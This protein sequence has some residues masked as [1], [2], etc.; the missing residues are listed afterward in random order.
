MINKNRKIAVI[1]V[2]IVLIGALF[3]GGYKVFAAKATS[4]TIQPEEIRR[5]S[6]VVTPIRTMVFEDQVIVSGNIE[7]KDNALVSTRISGTLEA[8]YVDEGD[9]VQAGKTK[10][11]LT[12]SLK[13]T[14][15]LEIARHDL[16]VA[17][18]S[19]REVQARCE[20]AQAKFDLDSTDLKRYTDLA[21]KGVATPHELESYKSQFLQSQAGL[22][23]T[24]A[25]VDLA[26]AQLS[27]SE[28]RL[29]MAEKDLADTL[30]I[31][32]ITGRVSE[33]L[34]EPG[35]MAGTG[36]AVLRIEDLKTL[37]VSAYLPAEYYGRINT[38][39]T[40]MHVKV[41]N[42]DL[43]KLKVSYKSPTVEPKLRTFEV[44][45]I[46]SKPQAEVVPGNLADV[47][48][49]LATR[50]GLGVPS[51]AIQERGGK[52]VIFTINNNYAHKVEINP[53]LQTNGWTEIL[54]SDISPEADVVTMGQYYLDEG[55]AVSVVG[56]VK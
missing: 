4:T 33:R 55:S 24:K 15:A 8:I 26:K 29:D 3:F 48:I 9:L 44:K 18:C 16:A 38:G 5:V 1:I 53:G 32:P 27:K 6:V 37:E 13:Q 23:H 7:S 12:D 30:V 28:S 20:Q 39:Q 2:V 19:L 52:D 31:A 41:G 40:E 43:G 25:L 50:K 21:E 14:K 47:T 17:K 42:V 36:I 35:E 49:V 45:C 56:E 34:R 51:E 10:L 46:I 54:G 11:F 22:K